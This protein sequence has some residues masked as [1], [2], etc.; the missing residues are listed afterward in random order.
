MLIHLD[1]LKK[2]FKNQ[3]DFLKELKKWGFKTNKDNKIIKNINELIKFH[4]KFEK[5]DLI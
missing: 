4:K 2:N 5:K 1:I 3:S